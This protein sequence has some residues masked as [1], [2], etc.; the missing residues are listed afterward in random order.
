MYHHLNWQKTS[1]QELWMHNN[2]VATPLRESVVSLPEEVV[3]ALPAIHALSGCDT[4]SKVGFKLQAFNAA[5]K[6]E[7]P[8]L[9]DFGVKTLDDDIPAER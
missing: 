8:V 4:T 5:Y 7:H 1:L 6:A 3:R 2:G 9:V